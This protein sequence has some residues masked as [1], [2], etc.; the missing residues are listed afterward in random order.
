[1]HYEAIYN[2]SSNLLKII[3]ALTIGDHFGVVTFSSKATSLNKYLIKATKVNKNKMINT[4]KSIGAASSYCKGVKG[5]K[6]IG[7]AGEDIY[8]CGLERCG[9][10]YDKATPHQC[11][12]HCN[13]NPSC[14]SYTWAP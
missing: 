7:G 8:G 9:A 1:M 3:S 11:A 6:Q 10:R 2:Y 14:K 12:Q 5:Y 4:I 13:R